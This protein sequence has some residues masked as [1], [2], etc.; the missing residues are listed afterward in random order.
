MRGDSLH[1]LESSLIRAA[2]RHLSHLI[3]PERLAV[4]YVVNRGGFVNASFVVS[5]GD[6]RVHV[7]VART[8]ESIRRLRRWRALAS[9]LEARYLAPTILALL[10][11]DAATEGTVF[12][13][14]HGEPP[15]SARTEWLVPLLGA[16][17][18]LHRD[19]ELAAAL[20]DA[21]SWSCREAWRAT[22]L[23]RF[24]ADLATV[25]TTRPPFVTPETLDALTHLAAAV[26][27]DVDAEAA[28][29][30]PA[31]AAVHG[32]L[33]R[34]NILVDPQ[35]RPTVLDWDDLHVGDPALDWGTLFGFDPTHPASGIAL[36]DTLGT[37]PPDV[38]ARLP[39]YWRSTV[40]DHAIDSLAD[41][42]EAVDAPAV[43]AIARRHA[44]HVHRAAM[45]TLS[46]LGLIP[47]E[48]AAGALPGQ[49]PP[50]SDRVP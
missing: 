28:F 3:D 30:T 9:R 13:F 43:T 50:P 29:D 46:V 42:V 5:D 33:W 44:E 14:V 38:A 41:W 2:R 45:H 16:I 32:D 21:A 39:L 22:F 7:K 37:I 15:D 23:D 48:L 26:T 4:S 20:G 17:S 47:S 1:A 25:R 24:E 31:V 36:P 11:I 19:A 49:L 10:P 40:I 18:R 6:A 34:N 35:G 27:R 8:P 12:Q